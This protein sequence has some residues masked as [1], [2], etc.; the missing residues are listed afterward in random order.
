MGERP[1]DM[2]QRLRDYGERWRET[3][4]APATVNIGKLSSRRRAKR[5]WWLAPATAA[6]V[7]AVIVGVQLPDTRIPDPA[8]PQS[9][10]KPTK[11]VPWAP[12]EPTHPQIPTVTTAAVPDPSAAA[13]APTC[14]ASDLRAGVEQGGAGGTSYLNVRLALVGDHPCRL[15]GYA[16][17]RPMDNGRLVDIP[18]QRVSDDSVYREPVLVAERHPAILSLGWLS[19]WCTTAVHNDSILALLPDGAG[20][21][22]FDGFGRSPFCSGNPGSGPTPIRVRPFQPEHMRQSQV[23]SAY[24]SVDVAGDL[25]RSAAPGGRVRFTVTLTARRQVVLDPCPDYTIA[26]YGPGISRKQTFAL[27]CAAVPYTDFQ[28]RPYLPA[29]TPVRFA[30]ETTAGTRTQDADKFV[31][32]LDTPDDTAALGGRL[33]VD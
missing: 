10:V 29:G 5:T 15:D 30:M 6:A 9:T 21:V 2:D 17:I 20:A 8:Q 19:N 11:V 14:R 26:Q 3:A 31:W 32:E 4:V 13:E 12:L 27:N 33:T 24:A 1:V 7:A 22:A 18:V 23:R 28:G 16:Q 25:M